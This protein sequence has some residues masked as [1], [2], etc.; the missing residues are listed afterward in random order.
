[1]VKD[2]EFDITS[3][4]YSLHKFNIPGDF[5]FIIIDRVPTFELELS[6]F[7]R[8]IMNVY[9]SVRKLG[10][11]ENKEFGLDTSNVVIETVP[12]SVPKTDKNQ[13]VRIN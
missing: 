4:Y 5:C 3:N 1:M 12:L 10:I 8:F 2:G 11:S 13:L 9:Y 6:Q 7:Q